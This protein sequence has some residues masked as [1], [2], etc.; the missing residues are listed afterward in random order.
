MQCQA[1]VPSRARAAWIVVLVTSCAATEECSAKFSFAAT[2]PDE[3]S[4]TAGELLSFTPAADEP[5]W[6]QARRIRDGR[7]GL[8]P[9]SHL[10]ARCTDC[11]SAPFASTGRDAWPATGEPADDQLGPK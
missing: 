10:D 8:V 5:G 2:Q 6:V 3:L 1:I 4:I 7:E 9:L 11:T